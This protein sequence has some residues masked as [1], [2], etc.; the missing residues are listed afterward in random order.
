MVYKLGSGQEG[1]CQFKGNQNGHEG[2][3]PLDPKTAPSDSLW[4]ELA[5]LN[6]GR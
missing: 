1:F 4:Q 2:D 6:H 3:I 5:G